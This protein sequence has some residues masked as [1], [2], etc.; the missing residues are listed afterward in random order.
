MIKH[1]ISQNDNNCPQVTDLKSLRSKMASVGLPFPENQQIILDATIQ[2]YSS[3]EN[4]Q[5][6][7]WYIGSEVTPGKHVCTFSSWRMGE[8]HFWKSDG[9]NLID[10][11][12]IKNLEA[13]KEK[14]LAHENEKRVEGKKRAQLLWKNSVDCFN[15]PYLRNKRL[16]HINVKVSGDRLL[17]PLYDI[18]GNVCSIQQI[19]PQGEKRFPGMPMKGYFH[20]LGDLEDAGEAF[21]TEGYATGL[22]VHLASNK[23]VIVAFSSNLVCV[24]GKIIQNEYPSLK[25]I[26]ASDNGNA[27]E[28]AAKD[29]KEYI[30]L[31]VIFPGNQKD[32]NDVWVKEGEEATTNQ[33]QIA[34]VL[35]FNDIDLE[36]FLGK[37]IPVPVRINHFLSEGTFNI[38]YAVAGT[39]KSRF[40][41][42]MA[43][44]IASGSPFID[45]FD[46]Y[47]SKKV[48]YIDTEMT[49]FDVQKRFMDIVKRS[50]LEAC[51]KDLF[52]LNKEKLIEK[53]GGNLDLYS[54]IHRR[55]IFPFL[56][57]F[58]VIFLDNF[59]NMHSDP[60]GDNYKPDKKEWQ[61]LFSYF[62]KL[63]S[64]G[65]CIVM[66]MHSNKSGYLEGV[67]Q[68]SNDAD[69]KYKLEPF[70]FP[71]EEALFQVKLV[72]EKC[73]DLP[74]YE[75][76]PKKIILKNMAWEVSNINPREK[77]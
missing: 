23:P 15:H 74:S 41:Y 3:R 37:E 58:G 27:G 50:S 77:N 8:H 46:T 6:D 22:S 51:P 63:K 52:V 72:Y 76:I 26:L 42:E 16:P 49:A 18:A 73:R 10:Q 55:R 71:E 35:E 43:F 28:K 33:L 59:N 62:Y 29:W 60:K 34:P 44:N 47:N 7:E 66:I 53:L 69:Y 13:L 39:G 30:S 25:L 11:E 48:L 21:V 75:Q 65:I 20:V 17:I 2:R 4:G 5:L 32:F 19:T 1:T 36:S 14:T 40:C 56:E 67:Q 12:Y 54:E 38:L 70:L 45:T 57:K 64:K 61:S 9:L 31:D 24:V 68:I